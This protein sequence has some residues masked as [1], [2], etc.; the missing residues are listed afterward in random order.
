MFRH[1]GKNIIHTT[2]GCASIAPSRSTVGE[3]VSCGSPTVD[4][5]GA[6]ESQPNRFIS[7]EFV[8]IAC[9]KINLDTK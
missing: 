4:R 3:K 9:H 8:S 5:L 2:F 7:M 6:I 1:G